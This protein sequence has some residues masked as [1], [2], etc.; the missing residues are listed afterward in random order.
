ACVRFPLCL[1]S[2]QPGDRFCPFGMKEEKKLKNFL[3]DEHVPFYERSRLPLL[4][5]KEKILWVVGVRLSNA[6]RISSETDKVLIMR[7]ERL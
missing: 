5:D 1:R 3:I 2:R 4:C 6:V 7:V